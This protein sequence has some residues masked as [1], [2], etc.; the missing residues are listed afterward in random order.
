MLTI[1]LFIII[2]KTGNNSNCGTIQTVV[3][4]YSSILLLW[5]EFLSPHH[6]QKKKKTWMLKSISNTIVLK[7]TVFRRW[8]GLKSRA[9]TNGIKTLIKGAWGWLVCPFCHMRTQ[10]EGSLCE[11][12]ALTRYQICRHL[13]LGL[14]ASVV[15]NK[16][17]LCIDYLSQGIY[18]SIRNWITTR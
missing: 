9:L 8:V 5:S 18:Y 6:H 16:L 4:V 13:D 10:L 11:D 17:L 14:T 12:S 1:T 15:G 2:F 7:D 3:Q